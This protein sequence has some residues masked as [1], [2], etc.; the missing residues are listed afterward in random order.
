M[1]VGHHRRHSAVD[2]RAR[3]AID[4]GALGRLVAVQG[5][6]LFHKPASYF[7]EA[8]W[9]RQKGS[10]PILNNIVHEIDNLR[11][12]A[13]E[14]VEVQAMASNA[15]RGHEVEDTV[16]HLAAF[17]ERRARH[18]HALRRGGEHTQLGADQRRER[19]VRA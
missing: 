2:D 12:L 7:D 14:I 15:R 1:L 9:R 4:S 18:V 5:S 6:A 19:R 13:G 3:E 11:M 17:R 16:E 8:P 10:G